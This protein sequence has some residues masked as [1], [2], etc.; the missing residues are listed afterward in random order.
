MPGA[1]ARMPCAWSCTTPHGWE[2]HHHPAHTERG[3]LPRGARG[4]SPKPAWAG[5]ERWTKEPREAMWDL[6]LDSMLAAQSVRC[7]ARL[8]GPSTRPARRARGDENA[9]GPGPGRRPV[10][11]TGAKVGAAPLPGVRNW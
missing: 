2:H 11:G 8:S 1:L 3:G 4:A 10:S 5:N 7:A 9:A 6:Q